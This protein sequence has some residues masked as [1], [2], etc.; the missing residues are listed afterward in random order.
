MQVNAWFYIISPFF[1][2]MSAAAIWFS[3]DIY[4]DNKHK[5]YEKIM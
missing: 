1:L 2:A 5:I 4:R 3:K